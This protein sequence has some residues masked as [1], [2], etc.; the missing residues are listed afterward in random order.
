M[1]PKYPYYSYEEKCEQVPLTFPPQHQ[2]MQPGL[3]HDLEKC[4]LLVKLLKK[5]QYL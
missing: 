1:I 2:D 3:L 5:P 4:Y